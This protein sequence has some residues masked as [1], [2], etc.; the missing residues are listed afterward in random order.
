MRLLVRHFVAPLF[1]AGSLTSCI[2]GPPPNRSALDPS[3]PAGPRAAQ[4]PYHPHLIAST[5]VF[6]DPNVGK[7]AQKMEH[8]NMQM[9]GM[10]AME[11][12]DDSK[13]PGMK[14]EGAGM[15]EIKA[16]SQS[17]PNSPEQM[18][19]MPGME[20]QGTRA[21]ATPSP[22]PGDLANTG[23]VDAGAR[24]R[25]D[26]PQHVP[27]QEGKSSSPPPASPSMQGMDHS[28]MQ[29]MDHSKMQGMQHGEQPAASTGSPGANNE[30]IAG[31]M[32]K[33]SEEMKKTS[34]EL[35]AKADAAKKNEKEQRSSPAPK[36]SP[37]AEIYSCPMHPEV[38]QSKPGKCPKCGM[39]LVKKENE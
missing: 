20:M 29:G 37:T 34:D 7:G 16:Q 6:L 17:K 12:M 28:Q 5:E 8:G 13:M 9:G 3:D 1:I 24:T 30:Q 19:G 14:K 36:S 15:K 35:K 18:Q 4:R 26:E 33:T 21:G 31:E 27:Q 2:V 23:G 38:Q 25:G 10:G 22:P 32:K 39:T 11:G